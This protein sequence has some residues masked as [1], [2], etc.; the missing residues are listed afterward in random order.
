MAEAENQLEAELSGMQPFPMPDEL[1]NRIELDLKEPAN[2]TSPWPDRFLLAA[3][4]SGA[5]AAC[6]LVAVLLVDFAEPD[7]MLAPTQMAVLAPH[8]SKAAATPLAFAHGNP[9]WADVLK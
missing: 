9:D 2:L 4:A 3:M 5:L 1:A 8:S 7:R 6:A